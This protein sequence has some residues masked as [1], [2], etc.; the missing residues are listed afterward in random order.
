MA[1][2][3]IRKSGDEILRKKSREIQEVTDRVR[4][5]LDDMAETMYHAE[6]GGLAACQVGILKRLVVIDIGEGLLKLVNPE[7]VLQKGE[8]IVEEGCLSF[9]DVWGRLKRPERVVV[10][11]LDEN[12]KEITV[13]GTGLLAKCLCHE[14][15]HLDGIV[16]KD[17]IIEFT[18]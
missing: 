4:T 1:L 9:P 16:F 13:E 2:R 7:F 17:K 5:I 11:A 14:L 6:G 15:D 8:Q 10:R 3:E 12:G 18:E